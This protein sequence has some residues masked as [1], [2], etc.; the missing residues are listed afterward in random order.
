MEGRQ[1]SPYTMMGCSTFAGLLLVLTM[2]DVP[3][4]TA[5]IPSTAPT[6][7]ATTAVRRGLK[8]AFIDDPFGKGTE[9]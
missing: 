3:I 4:E 2:V 5:R 1:R 8:D 9:E 6:A 7:A